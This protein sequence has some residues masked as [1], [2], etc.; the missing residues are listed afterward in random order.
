MAL[1]EA[2]DR[3]IY[4]RC[5]DL[6]LP[7]EKRVYLMGLSGKALAQGTYVPFREGIA[8]GW[9]EAFV[10]REGNGEKLIGELVRQFEV[11]YTGKPE[12]SMSCDAQRMILRMANSGDFNIEGTGMFVRRNNFGERMW[13]DY[14]LAEHVRITKGNGQ[15]SGF[16]FKRGK[17][18]ESVF[19]K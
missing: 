12:D 1:I 14:G 19:C 15:P 17:I 8:L 5:E 7:D 11:V 4:T 13:R 16:R 10:P 3:G 9:L 18:E 2:P 6:L